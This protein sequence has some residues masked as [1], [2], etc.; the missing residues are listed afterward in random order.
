M[1]FDR[2][3]SIRFEVRIKEMK[4]QCDEMH[5]YLKS[6]LSERVKVGNRS[7]VDFVSYT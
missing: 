4:N 2:S 7:A 6:P 1:I 3:M 5:C